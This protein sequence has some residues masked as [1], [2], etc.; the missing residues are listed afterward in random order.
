MPWFGEDGAVTPKGLAAT[1]HELRALARRMGEEAWDDDWVYMS[2]RV[3]RIE[4]LL[5]RLS[6]AGPMCVSIELRDAGFDRAACRLFR[7]R[8]R[9][10]SGAV[11]ALRTL[12]HP[13]I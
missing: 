7:C 2:R 4:V 9:L 1:Q 3:D 6:R 12:G 8:L 13:W 5:D 10:W 11:K